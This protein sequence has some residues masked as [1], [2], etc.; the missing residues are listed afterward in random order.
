M[1]TRQILKNYLLLFSLF[2]ISILSFTS[3]SDDQKVIATEASLVPIKPNADATK[4]SDKKFI[5][6]AYEF[7]WYQI[8]LSK[9]ASRRSASEEV[10]QFSAML[11]NTSRD[12]KTA[13][14]SLAIMKSIR[15]SST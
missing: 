6:S 9:L 3:C 15:I 10:K 14:G 4:E 1:L 5:V 12:T 2:L 13:L 7:N 11:E 8:M